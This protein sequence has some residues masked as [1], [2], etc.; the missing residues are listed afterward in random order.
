MYS[1]SM[2]GLSSGSPDQPMR[3]AKIPLPPAQVDAGHPFKSQKNHDSLLDYLKQRLYIGRFQRDKEL[4]RL[5]Q[6]DRA[7]AGWMRLSEEDKARQRKQHADGIPLAT[8]VNLPISFIHL[9]DMMTYFAQ[10]F[11]P[12]RG[13]F[14]HT[15]KPEEMGDAAQIVTLMNNHAIYGGYFREVLLAVYSLLKYNWGGFTVNWCKEDGLVIQK[16]QSGADT[17]ISQLRWQGNRLEAL[18][19]YNFLPDPTVHPTKLHSDGEFAGIAKMV[20]YYW[21]QSKAAQG[22][23]FNCDDV[24]KDYKGTNECL[25]YRN[26]PVRANFDKDESGGT[27]WKAILGSYDTT[28][29]GVGIELVTIYI[30]LNPT[31]FGLIPGNAKSN[32][33]RNRLEIWRFTIANNKALIDATYMNNIHGC[34]PTYTSVF[35]DDIMSTSQKSVAEILQPLQNFASSLLNSHIQQVRKKLWGIT[36]YDPSAVDL[37]DMP[38]GEVAARIPLKPT[39]YGRDVR[40]A[41]WEQDNQSETNQTVKDLSAMMDIISQFFPTQSLPSQIA[42]IDRAVDSQV[43]AVQQGAN[44]RQQKAARALDDSLFRN[45]RT[46]MYYNIIQ[47]QPDETEVMDYY[48]GEPIQIDLAKLRT[49]DLPFIIGQGLKAIDRQA[50]AKSLQQVIFALIQAPQAAQ[51]IDLLGLIDYWTSMIDI[52]ID[53]TQFA[54]KPPPP[55]AGQ[56]GQTDPTT[57][58][59]IT[60]AYAPSALTNPLHRG[61]GTPGQ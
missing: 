53:M 37:K 57:G 10:T 3:Y 18:D 20:S 50:A 42:S 33:A 4:D 27:D 45:I 44:R 39:A 14:Y 19:R 60:P 30:R 61:G 38:Q 1:E 2:N 23:Y 43:A 7:V 13:M 21:L 47:Y 48:T 52:D 58:Q 36:V 35:N 16:D 26:P 54:A 9:D 59:P 46:G 25:Y 15:G 5:V 22:T 28:G 24:L 31:E 11:S 56:P 8:E 29:L 51:G 17:V 40:T 32:E 55:V 41:I 34:I 6:I 12:N 49:T